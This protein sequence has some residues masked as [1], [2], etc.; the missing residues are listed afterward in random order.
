VERFAVHFS[1]ELVPN[2]APAF[3][4]KEEAAVSVWPSFGPMRGDPA[5]DRSGERVAAG[6]LV[7]HVAFGL[8]IMG[9]EQDGANL[10]GEPADRRDLCEDIG[11]VDPVADVEGLRGGWAE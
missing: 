4:A 2:A 1:D 5:V 9:D 3:H 8:T 11:A 10:A 6:D 7:A